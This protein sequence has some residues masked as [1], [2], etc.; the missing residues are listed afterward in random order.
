MIS[1]D[2]NNQ[3][4]LDVIETS[5]F[6]LVLDENVPETEIEVRITNYYYDNGFQTKGCRVDFN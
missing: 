5:L 3:K 2:R 1:L 6:A 4:N